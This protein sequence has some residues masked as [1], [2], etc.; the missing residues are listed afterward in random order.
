MSMRTMMYWINQ[1]AQSLR[2]VRKGGRPYAGPMSGAVLLTDG[3]VVNLP[4]FQDQAGSRALLSMPVENVVATFLH[5]SKGD[6]SGE[7]LAPALRGGQMYE[8][9]VDAPT[10]DECI[11]AAMTAKGEAVRAAAEMKANP[12]RDLA[13]RHDSLGVRPARC[14][15]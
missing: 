7:I 12:A 14:F 13:D 1:A 10:L 11:A 8:A 2:P 6:W 5:G 15:F 9:R 3:T 4:N